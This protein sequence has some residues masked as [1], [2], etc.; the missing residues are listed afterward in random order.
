MIRNAKGKSLSLSASES[1]GI[2]LLTLKTVFIPSVEILF[3]NHCYIF[4]C[5]C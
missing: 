3:D 5:T 4:T 2:G 1:T